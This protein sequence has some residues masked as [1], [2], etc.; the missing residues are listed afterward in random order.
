MP[1]TTTFSKLEKGVV[2]VVVAFCI[3]LMALI[4][5]C[6]ELMIEIVV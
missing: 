4:S 1:L 2:V 6:I 3:E 5:I